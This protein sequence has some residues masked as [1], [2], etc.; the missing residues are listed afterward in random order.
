MNVDGNELMEQIKESMIKKDSYAEI[1]VMTSTNEM[2][3]YTNINM[4]NC[5]D[6]DIAYLIITLEAIIEDCEERF[7]KAKQIKT[8]LG[9][10]KLGKI[11]R[12][13]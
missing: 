5:N 1:H 8:K 11:D 12:E 2:I 4:H 3:P 6:K 9:Y 7:P 13:S 10:K